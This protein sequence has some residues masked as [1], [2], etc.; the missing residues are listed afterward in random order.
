MKSPE[1]YL[2]EQ[3]ILPEQTAKA[4]DVSSLEQEFVRGFLLP[5]G[6]ELKKQD[7]HALQEFAASGQTSQSTGSDQATPSQE[8]LQLRQLKSAEQVEFVGFALLK[9]E[10]VLPIIHV[11][12]VIR[13]VSRTKLPSGPE[14]LAGVIN[15]RGKVTPLIDMARLLGLEE[16]SPEECGFIVVCRQQ[17][18]QFGLLVQRIT[19]MH[20]VKQECIE[21]DVQSHL[22][23]DSDLITGLIKLDDYL[24]GIVSISALIRR[25]LSETV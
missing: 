5:E 20:K 9:Q 23:E 17:D 21:W 3:V 2:Q 10:F 18:L 14:F 4:R 22:V 7:P 19:T 12:E 1:E 24:A 13:S 16:L 6:D 11:Q 15:L 25:A 8:E